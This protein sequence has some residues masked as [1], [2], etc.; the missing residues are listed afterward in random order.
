MF[1]K[2]DDHGDHN[3]TLCEDLVREI[4][5][6]LPLKHLIK[7]K[8]VS[9]LWCRLCTRLS[10]RRRL[11][12]GGF[13]YP[14]HIVYTQNHAARVWAYSPCNLSPEYDNN[15]GLDREFGLGFFYSA[16]PH[17]LFQIV[18][19]CNG[20]LL[21][22][23]INQKKFY[24]CNP[25]T[26]TW[27]NI[28]NHVDLLSNNYDINDP[29]TLGCA[30]LDFDPLVSPHFKVFR[31]Y[32]EIGYVEEQKKLFYRGVLVFSSENNEWVRKNAVEPY[33][34]TALKSNDGENSD[35]IEHDFDEVGDRDDRFFLLNGYVYR[36]VERNKVVGFNVDNVNAPP[37][38]IALPTILHES[39][40]IGHKS[41]FVAFFAASNGLLNYF[42]VGRGI[43]RWWVLVDCENG[44]E[45]A[46]KWEK[47]GEFNNTYP[48]D[49]Y[50]F[51]EDFKLWIVDFHPDEADKF[52]TIFVGKTRTS[53]FT[54]DTRKGEV[55]RCTAGEGIAMEGA[56]IMGSY[57][58]RDFFYLSPSTACIRLG[59]EAAD[60]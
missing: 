39:R 23:C 41:Y 31:V 60:R 56:L 4:L 48:N 33:P 21:L 29:K 38:E 28:G 55:R 26:K 14:S 10:L 6:L 50:F 24:V 22:D 20:I 8:C 36:L 9:K 53:I 57:D 5:S 18:D 2:N 40:K 47:K 1:D 13:Y 30:M 51:V 34:C 3:Q 58:F 45:W 25:L 7:F 37:T 16:H 42:R 59:F 49:N 46:L 32:S 52:F 19:S 27:I 43:V 11:G 15:A 35:A 54:C 44:Q 17:D 12:L